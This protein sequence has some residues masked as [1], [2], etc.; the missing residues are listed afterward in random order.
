MKSASISSNAIPPAVE[1]ARAIG[2]TPVSSI[3][4]AL[5][6]L[7]RS[8]G[9]SDASD[10]PDALAASCSNP[11]ATGERLAALR[12][13]F[14]RDCLPFGA[15]SFAVS[16][17]MSRSGRSATCSVACPDVQDRLAQ[18]G[19]QRIDRAA[20]DAGAG[21]DGFAAHGV[22]TECQRHALERLAL[23]AIAENVRPGDGE[24]GIGRPQRRYLHAFGGESFDP[25]A[26]GAQ[27]RPACAA[28]RQHR[29]AA[30]RRRAVHPAFEN[31]DGPA[32][33]S[34]SSDDAAPISRPSQSSRRSHARSKGEALKAFGNTRPLEPTKVSCPSASLQSRKALRRER[35]DGGFQMR[36]RLAVARKECGNGSLCVRLS[37]PRPAIR[38]LRPADGIAS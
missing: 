22:R 10:V 19:R 33:P 24:A 27:P 15:E 17:S 8:A 6:R 29:R 3:G 28:E 14:D 12:R 37:P 34:R 1:I 31:A 25:R 35:F 23:E 26:I 20:F 7:A 38:N 21:D 36:H 32:R 9:D 16:S 18:L 13:K 5:I 2:A 11:I 30:S 4:T